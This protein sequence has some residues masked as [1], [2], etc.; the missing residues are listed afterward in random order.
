M[1][2]NKDQRANTT[3]RDRLLRPTG[4]TNPASK[5]AEKNPTH[6]HSGVSFSEGRCGPHPQQ[7]LG[8]DIKSPHYTGCCAY[9]VRTQTAVHSRLGWT[10]NALFLEQFRYI[11]V[12][13]QLLNRHSNPTTYRRQSFPAPT[14]DGSPQWKKN[15][16][17]VPSRLGLSLTGATAFLLAWSVRWLQ[18]RTIVPY[19]PIQKCLF[20]S[21]VVAITLTLYYVFRRQWLHN[22]RIQAI[23]GASSLTTNAQNFDAAASAGITLIQEVELV[24][25]GYN[26]CVPGN[27]LRIPANDTDTEAIRY[28]LSLDLRRGARLSDVHACGEPHTEISSQCFLLTIVC[29]RV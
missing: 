20:A 24:S 1:G 23:E 6:T 8:K 22:L 19:N 21:A 2:F 29:T 11:I 26:M 3:T 14:G 7:L 4:S 12:A 15:G 5:T 16:G 13:S 17:F 25:R 18:S 27:L 9:S 28:L 10:E